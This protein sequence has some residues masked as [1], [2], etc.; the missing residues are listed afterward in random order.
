M[1]ND[2]LFQH[3]MQHLFPYYYAKYKKMA[4]DFDWVESFVAKGDLTENL[5]DVITKAIYGLEDFVVGSWLEYVTKYDLLKTMSLEIYVSRIM[6]FCFNKKLVINNIHERFIN[7]CA[8][9]TG[10][11]IN[12]YNATGKKFYK[13]T[14]RILT[15][16]FE[17]VLREDFKKRGGWKSLEKYLLS[18]DYVEYYETITTLMNEKNKDVLEE[19]DTKMMEFASRRKHLYL[20]LP[21][22]EEETNNSVISNLIVEVVSSIDDSLWTEIN[23]SKFNAVPST[24]I[25][26]ESIS[27]PLSDSNMEKL[28]RS[29]KV[30]GG[31][32]RSDACALADDTRS[33]SPLSNIKSVFG[34]S[35]IIEGSSNLGGS[36]AGYVLNRLKL[37]VEHVLSL[38]ESLSR[39]NTVIEG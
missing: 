7:I 11:G 39:C 10:I 33:E 37:N 12:I 26:Q 25:L 14:P 32:D 17:K 24:S 20:P 35:N 21:I 34:K 30:S 8:L 1:S 36:S 4:V 38:L 9:V 3:L 18:R 5:F 29:S 28:A 6:M 19:I 15:A 16:F 2:M 27:N 13:L 31:N 22:I 23:P